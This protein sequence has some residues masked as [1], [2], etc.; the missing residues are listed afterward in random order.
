M[1]RPTAV[2]TNSLVLDHIGSG[3]T[4]APPIVVRESTLVVETLERIRMNLTRRT[5]FL[6]GRRA[7]ILPECRVRDTVMFDF[8]SYCTLM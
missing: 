7:L 2:A 5:H 4:E 3:W 1:E 8:A 6:G